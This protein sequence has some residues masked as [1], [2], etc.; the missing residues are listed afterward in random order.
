[1][2]LSSDHT[3]QRGMAKC[4]GILCFSLMV[5][6]SAVLWFCDLSPAQ[7]IC[8]CWEER[9]KPR[10]FDKEDG[11]ASQTDLAAG[12][13]KNVRVGKLCVLWL[14]LF[15]LCL[16]WEVDFL[17]GDN[18]QRYAWASRWGE[19]RERDPKGTPFGKLCVRSPLEQAVPTPLLCC[20]AQGWTEPKGARAPRVSAVQH[21]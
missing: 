13:A 4:V 20:C 19:R 10:R 16:F 18:C 14:V 1:M 6:K 21:C 12:N 15:F 2:S 9:V 3:L 8:H 11:I 17:C 5:P 7:C